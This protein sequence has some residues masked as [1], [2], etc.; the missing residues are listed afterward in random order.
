MLTT[1]LE[2]ATSTTLMH[3]PVG[4]KIVL[5]VVFRDSKGREI[6]ASSKLSYRPHR[7][8]LTEIVPS[9]SNRTLTITL[10]S[11]GETVLKI[12]DTVEPTQNVYVRLSATEMLYP[13]T[14]RPIVSDIVCFTSPL[15]GIARWQSSNGHVE[16]LDVERGVGKLTQPG[17]THVAVKVAEQKLTTSLSISP[18]QRLN[19][20]QNC[21]SFVTN[22]AGSSFIFPVSV[23]ANDTAASHVAMT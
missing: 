2:P 22:A 21:P 18:A 4:A 15:G 19:F 1:N 20:A 7:F 9:D 3:L 8:D 12:W 14:R 16:W 23:E 11:A 10:K 13:L 6:T 17:N 5:K